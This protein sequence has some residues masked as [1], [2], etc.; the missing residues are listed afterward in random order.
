MWKMY[1]V[2]AVFECNRVCICY[3]GYNEFVLPV[4]IVPNSFWVLEKE[5]NFCWLDFGGMELFLCFG[6]FNYFFV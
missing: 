5:K 4:G 6:F 1:E 2:N 3:L